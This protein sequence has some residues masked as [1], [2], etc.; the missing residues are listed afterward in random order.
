[1][2]LLVHEIICHPPLHTCLECSLPARK[3]L[4]T[5]AIDA[6]GG[7]VLQHGADKA[8]AIWQQA[9]EFD[10]DAVRRHL[11]QR[12]RQSLCISV[13]GTCV[14]TDAP[15]DSTGKEQHET[16]CLTLTAFS[17][18]SEFT[19]ALHQLWSS[20]QQGPRSCIDCAPVALAGES[21]LQQ[22]ASRVWKH[23][24]T[25]LTWKGGVHGVWQSRDALPI[26][27]RRPAGRLLLAHRHVS[28]CTQGYQ[29]RG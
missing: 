4:E 22:E 26:A 23:G 16:C 3:L 2:S 27:R 28:I 7:S 11:R 12:C 21:A 24:E 19:E 14:R 29:V 18:G 20:S 17:L 8:A 5:D 25:R 9:A 6:A 15:E 10:A 1:M 13:C